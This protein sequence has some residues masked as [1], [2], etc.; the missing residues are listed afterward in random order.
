MHP[1]LSRVPYYRLDW[2]L[3]AVATPEEKLMVT[4]LVQ[5]QNYNH[6]IPLPQRQAADA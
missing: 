2:P 1:L 4:K 5:L 6:L 3:A